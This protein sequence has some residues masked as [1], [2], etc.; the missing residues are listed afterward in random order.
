M[1][2][3]YYLKKADPALRI[4]V[5]EREFAGYGASGRNGGWASG[6]LAG[7]RDR[8][9]ELYGVEATKAQQRLM[10]EAVDEIV[11]VGA[12]EGIEADVVKGGTLRIACSPS[13][14]RRLTSGVTE[15]HKWGVSESRLLDDG[16]LRER[17]RIPEAVKAAYTPH[18]ARM[19]PAR[20]VRGLAD[21]VESLGV[22]IRESTAVTRIESGRAHTDRGV[23]RAPVI[24]RATEGYTASLA[25][26]RRTW[27]P[28]NSSMIV[29]EPLP[30]SVWDEIGW[31]GGESLGDKCY[32]HMYGQRTAD[33]RIAIGGRGIPYRFG[34]ATDRDGA[35]QE[36]TIRSLTSILHR[37]FLATRGHRVEHAWCG[38]LGVP[39]TGVPARSSTRPPDSGTPADTSARASPPPTWPAA[40]CATWSSARTPNSP[41][42]PGWATPHGSGRSNRCAGWACAPCIWL[43]AARTARNSA[44]V[45]VRPGWRGR[46]T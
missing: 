14:V 44:G 13:Q 30:E 33:G 26:E 37:R 41:G 5:L 9:A 40:P 22:T 42:S 25:G 18:C 17:L 35:T 15:D 21:V 28:M 38:V 3:A 2:T 12:A 36:A 20:Y 31:S 8:F 24:L 46:P 11:A 29:T 4:V 34:S 1:W 10:H 27:L 32:S 23:V 43:T 19:Q 45:S 6:L 7:S 16:E 39:G